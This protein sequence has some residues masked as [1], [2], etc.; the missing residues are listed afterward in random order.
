MS[1]RRAP[2]GRIP[3]YCSPDCQN[4]ARRARAAA[5]RAAERTGRQLP[6]RAAVRTRTRFGTALTKALYD[7]GLSREEISRRLGS[8]HGIDASPATVYNWMHGRLPRNSAGCRRLVAALEHLT[9]RSPGE[10]QLLLD[11]DRDQRRPTP[12]AVATT[13]VTEEAA[14]TNLREHVL[15]LASSDFYTVVG[16]DERVL[17]GTDRR[18]Y[19]RIVRLTVRALNGDTD[20]YRLV[21]SPDDGQ[22][23][24]VIR[25]ARNCR[26]GRRVHGEPD[27]LE[28]E[29]LF[30]RVLD[31]GAVHTFD[32]IE[33]VEH[34]GRLQCY[35][36]RGFRDSKV[37]DMRMTVVFEVPPAQV[38]ACRW[39]GRD[40]A[41]VARTELAVVKGTVTLE[42]AHPAPGLHGIAWSW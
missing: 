1:P 29:L 19:K 25:A 31:R 23:R 2:T 35:A 24:S 16:V 6:S 8:D 14:V 13:P 37:A 20:C 38:W 33:T 21:Y 34:R 4:R 5:R 15:A 42:Q 36:R 17:I 28:V 32:Y 3:G 12:P 30:D 9:R 41:P 22:S 18:G 40:E 10:L 26:E 27:L 39:N 7:C 11:R